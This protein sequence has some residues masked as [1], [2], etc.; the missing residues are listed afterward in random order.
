MISGG[1]TKLSRRFF[2]MKNSEMCS[3]ASGGEI[4]YL[5]KRITCMVASSS[6]TP[7][8]VLQPNKSYIPKLVQ[9]FK[10]DGKKSKSLPHHADLSVYHPESCRV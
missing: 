8:I 2:T 5:K 9:M 6:Q 4:N 10:L 1:M 7:G 3:V